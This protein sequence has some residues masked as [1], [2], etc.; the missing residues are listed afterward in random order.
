[1]SIFLEDVNLNEGELSLTE[2][3]DFGFM[4][5][6]LE[7]DLAWANIEMQAM[8]EEYI[9]LKEEDAKKS[10]DASKSFFQKVKDFFVKLGQKIRYFVQSTLIKIADRVGILE[11]VAKQDR[12]VLPND[13]LKAI[14]VKIYDPMFGRTLENSISMAQN[15]I[16]TA[17]RIYKSPN[18]DDKKVDERLKKEDEKIAKSYEKK[19]TKLD[20]T[21][22]NNAK[23]ML[24]SGKLTKAIAAIKAAATKQINMIKFGISA[25]DAGFKS[26]DDAE[27]KKHKNETASSRK[28]I[29]LCQKAISYSVKATTQAMID[30][31]TI[32]KAGTKK[33]KK[34]K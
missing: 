13:E 29:S 21:M 4:Q 12:K 20:A 34:S 33:V 6:A 23:A 7:S 3:T 2:A 26:K 32:Y 10:S 31:W 18:V 15:L 8:K 1:M 17:E 27:I 9:A 28:A 24:A 19:E 30:A 5:L 16:D 22:V 14:K 25:S 11:R